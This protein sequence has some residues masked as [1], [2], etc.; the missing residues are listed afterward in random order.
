MSHAKNKVSWCLNKAK[1]ELKE[2]GEHRG[3]VQVEPNKVRALEHIKKA[4]HNLEGQSISIKL[5][6]LIG[7]RV[8]SFIQCINHF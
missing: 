4:E 6:S 8:L 1:K 3:L 2:E 7:L 5:D